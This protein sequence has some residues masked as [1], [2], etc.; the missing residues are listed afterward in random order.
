MVEFVPVEHDPFND[1]PNPIPAGRDPFAL[2][3]TPKPGQTIPPQN[4][5]GDLNA[6]TARAGRW[7]A[8]NLYALAHPPPWPAPPLPAQGKVPPSDPPSAWPGALADLA[9]LGMMMIPGIGEEGLALK[10]IG[11]VRQGLPGAEMGTETLAS[12]SAGLYNPPVKPLRPFSDDYPAGAPGEARTALTTGID[13]RPLTA[14]FIAGRRVVGEPD[15]AISPAQFNALAEAGTGNLPQGVPA[16][17]LPRRSVGAYKVE[18]GPNG[19]VRSILYNQNLSDSS[20]PKVIGHEIGHM[21][22]DL[23]GTIPQDGIKTELKQ[24]Y[25]TLNTG[26]ERTRNLTGPQHLGYSAEEAPRELMAT[27]IDAYLAF[28]NYVKTV[29]PKT[30]AAIRDAVNAHPVLSKFIQFNAIPAIAAA[31]AAGAGYQLVPIDHDPF[32]Q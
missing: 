23:A 18:A 31:G 2:G 27:A 1:P 13:G 20:A 15:E 24:V 32:A 25:N 17:A 7:L 11:A 5:L 6:I 19:P 29:A 4:V 12:R 9:G 26:Q 22:D 21:I 30:A 10:G 8:P 16:A 3:S 28:P 14:P